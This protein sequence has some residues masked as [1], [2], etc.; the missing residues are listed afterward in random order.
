MT[1]LLFFTGFSVIFLQISHI[2]ALSNTYY[3][4][5]TYFIIS[6]ALIGFGAS[7]TF[8]AFFKKKLINFKKVIII[9]Q[10]LLFFSIPASLMAA[11]R[12]PLNLLYLLYDFRQILLLS[13]FSFLLLIPFFFSG[14]ITGYILIMKRQRRA[15]FYGINLAGSGFGGLGAL[16]AMHYID[17]QIL[18]IYSIIPVSAGLIAV[19]FQFKF[20]FH[21][22][23]IISIPVFSFF[24]I[25]F[26]PTGKIDQYK[27]LYQYQQLE[28]QGDAELISSIKSPF[29]K[30]EAWSSPISHSTLFAGLENNKRPPP[31]LTLFHD[32]N[33]MNQLFRIDSL[34]EAEI[35]D[36]TIQSTPYRY[37]IN[38]HV[39]L[40]GDTGL[41]NLWLALRYNAASVTV[42]LP[43]KTP[44]DFLEKNLKRWTEKLIGLPQI[45]IIA[46]DYRQFLIL[47]RNRFDIIQ[48][49]SAESLKGSMSGLYTFQEDYLLTEETFT[50]AWNSL[51]SRGLLSISRGIQFPNKDNIKILLSFFNTAKSLNL[52]IPERHIMQLSNYL[53]KITLFTKKEIDP[54]IFGEIEKCAQ[55][56]FLEID[57]YPGN[58][59]EYDRLLEQSLFDIRSPK[60][61]RPFFNSFFR[62]KSIGKLYNLYG[63]YWFRESDLGYLIL[64]V[65][66]VIILLIAFILILLPHITGRSHISNS[67]LF[68]FPLIGFSFMCVEM[69]FIQKMTLFLGNSSY[70]IS[71]VLTCLLISSG[72]GSI[73]QNKIKLD[74]KKKIPIAITVISQLSLIIIFFSD[75]IVYINSVLNQISIIAT[76]CFML[77]ICSITGFF[78]GWFFPPGLSHLE[79]IDKNSLPIA[80]ALNGFASVAASPLAILL[81]ISYGFPIPVLAAV[82]C[83]ILALL[84]Y[85]LSCRE[86]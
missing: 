72:F 82:T 84:F 47:N 79:K 3:G 41:T 63:Y 70:G 29:G 36:Y 65:T 32:G 52:D 33:Y 78:M 75:Q 35:L 59:I 13:L 60:D 21:K 86:K 24:I 15:F 25:L 26:A 28:K 43:D 5:L 30:I 10:L 17:P 6:L 37:I 1:V 62:W 18:P 23:M 74:F 54:V 14:L 80:W 12:I 48:F 49:V 68:Y 44:K 16:I 64:L 77:C 58:K 51:T 56:L 38:P 55:D 66:F 67:F 22:L 69:V 42:L 2:R 81:S 19:L 71:L 8:L 50:T 57:F 34:S 40:I 11:Y 61:N 9:L 83:Y 20:P 53:A 31:Q 39:L 7:G 85:V 27:D 45:N 46:Q 4:A 73:I 76:W